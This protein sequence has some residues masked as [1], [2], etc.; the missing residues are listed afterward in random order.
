MK[1]KLVIWGASGH[2][3][4]VA[5]IVRL[6]NLFE[7]VGFL[8]N[9]TPQ[10]RGEIFAGKPILGGTEQLEPLSK[11]GVSF[12]ILA[13][14]DGRARR[15]LANSSRNAGF[16]LACAIHPKAIMAEDVTPGLG[17]VVA[18]GAVINPGCQIG[19]NVIINTGAT[20]DHD[21]IIGEGAHVCPGTHLAG[22]VKVGAGTWVGIGSTVIDRIEIGAESTVGAG[23]V[24]VRNIPPG[25]VAYGV[26]AR[27]VR[28][29]A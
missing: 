12:M 1:P 15:Q 26:P 9:V 29:A 18:A 24:V 14:G 4:V 17:T 20:V 13:L 2:A 10:R 19:E 27:V 21:C 3:R 11:A 6:Q 16:Q 28:K 8:D 7:I 25:V 22:W 23:S 5:D